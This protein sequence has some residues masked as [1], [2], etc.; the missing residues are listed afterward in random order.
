MQCGPAMVF[1]VLPTKS[2]VELTVECS[3][4]CRT[5]RKDAI[6]SFGL[7]LLRSG[8]TYRHT[9]E[10]LHLEVLQ[11]SCSHRFCLVKSHQFQR[12]FG[13]DICEKSWFHARFRKIWKNILMSCKLTSENDECCVE[14]DQHQQQYNISSVFLKT[15]FSAFLRASCHLQD[16]CAILVSLPFQLL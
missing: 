10:P 6:F 16:H 9:T 12:L 5:H 1:K 3:S 11:K 14:N 2:G 15:V 4:W 13:R 7:I 8:V